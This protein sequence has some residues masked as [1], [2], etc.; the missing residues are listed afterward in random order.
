LAE[1]GFEARFIHAG[2]VETEIGGI[3]KEEE[4]GELVL[5]AAF[6]QELADPDAIAEF[7]LEVEPEGIGEFHRDRKFQHPVEFLGVES[8]HR[9]GWGEMGAKFAESDE[10]LRV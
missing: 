7:A 8:T 2:Q 10:R 1:D 3:F 5:D 6:P 9:G 4:T